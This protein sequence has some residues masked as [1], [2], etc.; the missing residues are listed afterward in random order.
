MGL[1]FDVVVAI[2]VGGAFLEEEREGK[3]DVR[4]EGREGGAVV[5]GL[6]GLEFSLGEE[7]FFFAGG[8]VR[9]CW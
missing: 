3:C 4:A 7:F 6:W 8:K 1:S 2:A 5:D 9:G